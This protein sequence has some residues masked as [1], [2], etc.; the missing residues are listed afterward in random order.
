V[1]IPVLASHSFQ[2]IVS[3]LTHARPAAR[4]PAQPSLVLQPPEPWS[5]LIDHLGE[6]EN[7]ASIIVLGGYGPDLMCALL[8]AG[9]P[10]V[11]H[12]RSPE[13]VESG[14]V[15][16]LI[17]PQL[18]SLEW[19][20]SAVG[21]ILRALTANGRLVLCIDPLPSMQSRVRAMLGRQGFA[22]FRARRAHGRLI[23]SAELPK[24]EMRRCA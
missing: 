1:T 3:M 20:H 17:I 16:L 4:H 7:E 14:S 6:I 10:H 22:A 21:P 24:F 19:L 11:T 13:H 9:A 18:P 23:L 15:G 12:L 2:E 8:R 5:V